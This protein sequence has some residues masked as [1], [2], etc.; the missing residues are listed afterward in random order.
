MPLAD[1]LRAFVQHDPT[2]AL[3]WAIFAIYVGALL[4]ALK[5]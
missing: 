4:L 1:T 3:A 5:N 2:V